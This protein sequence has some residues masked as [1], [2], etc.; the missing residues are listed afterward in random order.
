MEETIY[1][2][3]VAEDQEAVQQLLSSYITC[4]GLNP[5]IFKTVAQATRYIETRNIR[6]KILSDV[7]TPG[8]PDDPI[9]FFHTAKRM[10]FGDAFAFYTANSPDSDRDLIEKTGALHI[11]KDDLGALDRFLDSN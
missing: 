9:N 5:I 4:K 11:L 6:P 1:D 7:E 2:V 10:G 3:I 8:H